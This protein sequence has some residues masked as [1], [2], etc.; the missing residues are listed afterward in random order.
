MDDAQLLKVTGPTD[1]ETLR[2]SHARL[3]ELV[4]EQRRLIDDKRW[5]NAELLEQIEWLY[6]KSCL[7][8]Q[9]VRYAAEHGWPTL[10]KEETK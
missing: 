8:H 3:L 9:D 5:E 7:S 10:R 2:A 1:V 6:D 4:E